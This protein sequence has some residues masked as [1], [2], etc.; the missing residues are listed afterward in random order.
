MADVKR[1]EL[2]L[3]VGA[4]AAVGGGAAVA[5]AASGG[6]S[7]KPATIDLSKGTPTL[8]QDGE[9]YRF[10][11]VSSKPT[12]VTP[13]GTVTEVT[14]KNFPP[15]SGNNAGVFFL[16]MKPGALREPHWHPNAWE[17]DYRLPDDIGLSTMF[18][19]MPTNTFSQT[20][21]VSGTALDGARKSPK[22]LLIVQRRG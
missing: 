14:E 10:P 6:D 2:L 18:G 13:G 9:T 20:L 15:F 1:R 11:L 8:P 4:A 19:G 22:T 12:A 17:M 7:S 5:V 16:V 21:G 3:G